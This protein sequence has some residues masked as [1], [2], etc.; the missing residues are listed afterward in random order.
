MSPRRLRRN[1]F[2][3]GFFASLRA[4]GASHNLK[5]IFM[6]HGPDRPASQNA[7]LPLER[8]ASHEA[9]IAHQDRHA[10]LYK[11]RWL[12]GQALVALDPSDVW[13]GYCGLCARLV[14]FGVPSL[15][16]GR[17]PNLREEL[18]CEGCGLNARV[19]AGLQIMGETV[20]SGDARVYMTEQASTGF[21]WLQRHYRHAFGSEYAQD[22]ATRRVLQQYLHDL[23]GSGDIRFEDV[24]RLGFADG[25]L[26]VIVSFDV[27]EH[28]PDYRQALREFAR[29]LR[30]GGALVL[31]APFISQ[32]QQTVVRARVTADG[33]IE[34]LLPAEYH[35]DPLGEGGI[36][37]YYHFGWDLLDDLREAGFAQA[38]MT[39]GWAPAMGWG[40]SLWT[41]RAIR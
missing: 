18:V 13:P 28:V 26:D 6:P 1:P 11:A 24:T 19:R 25:S 17:E 8:F 30:R 37:C 16:Q 34:H 21:V 27:L 9:W 40:D 7:A 38:E 10:E 31:T 22:D 39:L 4:A 36:L 3:S 14:R 32:S 15:A 29:T 20:G 2:R 41:L 12:F 33:E 5:D 23:G 35:G